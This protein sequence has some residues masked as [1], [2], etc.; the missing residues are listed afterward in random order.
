MIF[1]PRESKGRKQRISSVLRSHFGAAAWM[2]WSWGCKKKETKEKKRRKKSERDR[3]R[4]TEEREEKGGEGEPNK[5]REKRARGPN[6]LP[7]KFTWCTPLMYIR[8]LRH[9]FT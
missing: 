7:F 8:L 3:D 2:V 6:L 1:M 5:E 9:L 4:E